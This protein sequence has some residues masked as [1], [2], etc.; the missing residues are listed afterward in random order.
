MATSGG[1]GGGGFEKR[2]SRAYFE[3]YATS[4][5]V[6]HSIQRAFAPRTQKPGKNVYCQT[7]NVVSGVIFSRTNKLWYMPKEQSGWGAAAC[8]GNESPGNNDNLIWAVWAS[9]KWRRWRWWTGESLRVQRRRWGCPQNN[10]END[11]E[12]R[13]NPW[14]GEE[15]LKNVEDNWVGT[16]RL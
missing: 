15:E 4:A 11:Y 6:S 3:S 8:R 2:W 7:F 14:N 1:G 10:E 5:V 13:V 16:R 9:G 12:T